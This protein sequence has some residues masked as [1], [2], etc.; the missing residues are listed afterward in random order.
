MKSYQEARKKFPSCCLGA[1]ESTEADSGETVEALLA[2]VE[3][4]LDLYAEDQD[5]C[6]TDRQRNECVRFKE[7]FMS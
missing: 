2:A 4:E 3:H 1:L 5:G 7:W 6:I